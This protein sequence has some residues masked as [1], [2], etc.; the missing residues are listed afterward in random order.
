MLKH[1][2][3]IQKARVKIAGLVQQLKVIGDNVTVVPLDSHGAQAQRPVRIL[4]SQED[5]ANKIVV[6]LH[7]ALGTHP[8]DTLVTQ[9]RCAHNYLTRVMTSLVGRKTN[10]P[11]AAPSTM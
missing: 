11:M 10:R 8:A 3:A 7:R 1:V 9:E 5:Y 4:D 2:I 6:S